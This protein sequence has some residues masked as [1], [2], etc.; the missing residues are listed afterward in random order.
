VR[1]RAL[2]QPPAL[3]PVQAQRAVRPLVE[4]PPQAEAEQGARRASAPSRGSHPSKRQPSGLRQV[5]AFSSVDLRMDSRPRPP[6]LRGG[7]GLGAV[8]ASTATV[9]S[10]LLTR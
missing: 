4:P 2:A 8:P 5:W 3:R 10:V 6:P 7:A 9:V 1:P